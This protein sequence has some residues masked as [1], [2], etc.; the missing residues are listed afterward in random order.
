MSADIYSLTYPLANI[1][2]FTLDDNL[3]ASGFPPEIG[4][5]YKLPKTNLGALDVFPLE[6]LQMALSQLDVRTLADFRRIN[7]LA[8]E[9]V[10]SVLQYKAITTYA[11]NALH[12]ILSIETGQWI[13]C[14]TLYERLCRAECE[15]CGDFG[16]Y[17]YILACRRVCFCLSANN[18]YLPLSHSEAIRK[19]GVNRSI[20]N[21]LPQMRSVTV[22]G[23]YS[24][25][26]E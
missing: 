10:D 26:V 25:K 12:G 22:P 24:P 6:F 13:S 7:Q 14:E 19:F 2:D 15:Q 23:T 3:S 18:K 21:T 4:P 16:G 20:L 5:A 11:R 9:A 1:R 17:L 8:M